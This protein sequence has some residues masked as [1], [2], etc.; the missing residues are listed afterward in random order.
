VPAPEWLF[1]IAPAAVGIP[2][3]F[4]WQRRYRKQFKLKG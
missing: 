3:L 2:V 4:W 1:W